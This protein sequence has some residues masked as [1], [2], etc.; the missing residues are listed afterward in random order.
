M[1]YA[2]Y[3]LPD[4]KSHSITEPLIDGGY[5]VLLSIAHGLRMSDTLPDGV[6]VD[7]LLQYLLFRVLQGRGL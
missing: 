2:L 1:G 6:T 7:T 4:L 3:L 5:Y